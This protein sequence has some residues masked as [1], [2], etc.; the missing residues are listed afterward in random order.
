M[1][2]S[3]S[4]LAMS[5]CGLVALLVAS[6]AFAG[7]A[8]TADPD[9]VGPYAIGHTSLMFQAPLRPWDL[10]PRPLPVEVFYPVDPAT[11][12]SL[13]PEAVYPLDPINGYWPDTASSD[14][15]PYGNDRAYEAPPPSAGKPFPLVVFSPGLGCPIWA[16]NF[17]A[18]RLA[19]HG[20]AVAVIYHYGDAFFPGER[21]DDYG[22][23]GVNRPL[24]MSFILDRLLEKNAVSG[25]PLHGLVNPAL[26]AAAGWWYGGYAATVQA[27]GV[28][29]IGKD[30]EDQGN[31]VP[32]SAYV[33]LPSDSRFKAILPLDGSSWV[34]KFYELARVSVPSMGLGEEWSTLKEIF[35]DPFTTWQARQHAAFQGHPNYRVDV[36][37]AYHQSFSNFCA[38]GHMIID[39]GIDTVDNAGWLIDWGCAPPLPSHDGNLLVSKYAIAFLKT[40]LVGSP[41]YQSLLTPG[42]ALKSAPKVEFFVTEKRN[43]NSIDEDWPG[44]FVY[45]PHQPGSQQA[46]AAKDSN[47]AMPITR[48]GLPR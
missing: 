14:W 36:T 41:S 19:S 42:A 2:L 35:G 21:W 39:K 47:K 11:I 1:K 20:F 17:L 9:K 22:V 48:V 10:G 5:A 33:P 23:T 37:G 32:A 12:T 46:K 30:M 45:F 4:F 25:D 29:N 7:G 16:H 44:Y 15:E 13:T 26:I 24:D 43:P 18:G 6:G 34:M 28:D 27:A 3:R 40:H 31:W 8:K 38:A